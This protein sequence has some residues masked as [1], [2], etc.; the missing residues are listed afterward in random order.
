[1][2]LFSAIWGCDPC[3]KDWEAIVPRDEKDKQV[4]PTCGGPAPQRPTAPR[5][6]RA[7]FRDGTRRFDQLR[8]QDRLDSAMSEAR[9]T[10]DRK[11]ILIEKDR[12]AKKD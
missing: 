3:G 8:A 9:T 4:C 6:L 10:E 2:S 12:L 11:K 1:M 7:S 5:V